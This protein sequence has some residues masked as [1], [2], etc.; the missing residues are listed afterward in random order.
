[1]THDINLEGSHAWLDAHEEAE[2]L[3]ASDTEALAV[4]STWRFLSRPVLSFRQKRHAS[5]VTDVAT[6]LFP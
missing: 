1:M 6:F 3:P 4:P 5:A 2:F